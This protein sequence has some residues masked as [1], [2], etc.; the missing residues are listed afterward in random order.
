MNVRVTPRLDFL[1]T[2]LNL[3]AAS[4]IPNASW[5][6]FQLE[7]LNNDSTFAI[8]LKARQIAF[9]W[10]CAAEAVA[11]SVLEPKSMTIFISINTAE[12]AEKI[13]Y[14]Q[15]VI[16]AL[17]AEVRPKLIVEN[18]LALELA[19]GSRIL[20]H[21]SRPIRGKAKS[22]IIIDECAHLLYDRDIYTSVLP[23]MVKGGS[24]RI[25]SSPLG[26]RGV[27][28]EIYSESLRKYPGYMRSFVP[29]W[30]IAA[31]CNDTKMAAT[32][33]PMM[34][35]AERINQFGTKRLI[36][37]FEN[38]P[39][40]DFQ[41]EFEC[42][43]SDDS[44]SWLSWDDILANQSLASEDKLAYRVANDCAS[45][46]EA[47]NELAIEIERGQVEP[48]LVAGIDIGRKHDRTEI[49]AVGE[50]AA[51]SLPYRLGITLNNVK[52]D[53]QQDVIDHVMRT[54]PIRK[55]MID[56]TGLGAQ[57]AETS[58]TRHGERAEGVT[59]TNPIKELMSVNL[60]VR[61]QRRQLP[62]PTD[63][64]LNYQLHSIK[65]KQTPGAH[66]S[67]D[68]EASKN[69]HDDKYW[70]LALAV[71]AASQVIVQAAGVQIDVSGSIG[72]RLSDDVAKELGLR[73]RTRLFE[74]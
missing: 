50:S 4:G 71:H 23:I 64:D 72:G 33:A 27:F 32:V 51:G 1:V 37:I 26:A 18:K 12:A 44:V 55:V 65:K 3:Q 42:A 46:L 9:S 7:F 54:L 69:G 19:N 66:I 14:A 53:D 38:M 35:T 34:A 24:L 5:E 22:H 39:L 49:V 74:R 67:F 45:A 11:R 8:L 61:I 43:W 25:G 70:A 62:L 21:P 28:W 52:F 13:R 31:F 40:E 16:E 36:E 68:S 30:T 56:Q 41:Q 6:R 59:F 20:S 60:K 58:V 29:W 10:T 15:S 47:T 63:R 73:R 2:Y 57:L 17:D 48:V